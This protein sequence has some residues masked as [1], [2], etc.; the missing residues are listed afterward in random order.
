MPK[1]KE[2]YHFVLTEKGHR[3][4]VA[5][6]ITEREEGKPVPGGINHYSTYAE[7]VPVKWIQKGYVE[8]VEK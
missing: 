5:M 4:S 1:A 8:E 6:G 2:G 3:H 7:A